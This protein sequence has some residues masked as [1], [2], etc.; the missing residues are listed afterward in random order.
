MG[1]NLNFVNG[2]GW[3]THNDA[4][5]RQHG[6]IQGLDRGVAALVRDLEN[7]RLLDKTLAVIATEFGRPAQFDAGGGRGHHGHCFSCVFAGGGLRT[8]QAIGTTDD[9]AMEVVDESVSVPDFFATIAAAL[10]VDPA[11]ELMADERPVP[12][13]DGGRP[14]AKLFS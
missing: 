13:T 14:I 2:A 8:G 7:T 9:L 1:F 3:D 5:L 10:G 6:L 11:K 4:Q 12:I